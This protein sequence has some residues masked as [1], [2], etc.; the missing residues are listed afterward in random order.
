MGR[1]FEP[2]AHLRK[3]WGGERQSPPKN[4]KSR[5]RWASKGEL[6]ALPFPEVVKKKGGQRKKKNNVKKE[7]L[8]E[9]EGLTSRERN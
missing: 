8:G 7:S 4:T 3:R 5:E 6:E 2:M 9:K 1:G